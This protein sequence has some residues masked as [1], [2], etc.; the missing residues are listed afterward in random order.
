MHG[1]RCRNGIPDEC[2]ENYPSHHKLAT[3]SI[4]LKVL[5]NQVSWTALID[6]TSVHWDDLHSSGAGFVFG[7]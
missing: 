4:E 2:N 1:C 5:H 7:L 6:A 3:N